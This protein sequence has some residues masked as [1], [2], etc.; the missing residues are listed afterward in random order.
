MSKFYSLIPFFFIFLISSCDVKTTS[1]SYSKLK[2]NNFKLNQ[3]SNNGEQLYSITSPISTIN[4]RQQIY[5]LDKTIINFFDNNKLKYTINSDTSTLFNDE[6]KIILEGNI[7]II[8]NAEDK[9]IINAEK[10]IWDI[11]KSKFQLNGNV[12]LNNKFINLKSS[13]AS[14]NKKTNIIEFSNPVSYKYK[15]NNNEEYNI[16]SENAYYNLKNNKVIFNSS[17]RVKTK[18]V[19]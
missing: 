17:K 10:F 3:F 14:L 16:S 15:D 5:N 4:Q 2:I 9:T 18:F 8:D 11:D 12:S 6:K 7:R 13:K 1:K 19:Y